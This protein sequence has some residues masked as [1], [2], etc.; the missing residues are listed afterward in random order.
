L[1]ADGIPVLFRPFHEHNHSFWWGLDRWGSNPAHKVL[2]EDFI[3]L[4]KYTVDYMKNDKGVRNFLYVYSP[5]GFFTTATSGSDSYGWGYPGDD[6][7]D[8]CGFDMYYNT[9][10]T[11][12]LSSMNLS[13]QVVN[14]FAKDHG[15][16]AALTE[17]G[18]NAFSKDGHGTPLADTQPSFFPTLLEFLTSNKRNYAYMQTWRMGSSSSMR[19]YPYLITPTRAFALDGNSSVSP[20]INGFLN[21]GRI[22]MAGSHGF[23]ELYK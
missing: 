7:V 5:N 8:I 18:Q 21:S 23:Y 3:R 20:F 14:D 12:N 19:Y 15:K 1:E 6:Y 13:C 9:G 16:V 22:V 17:F 10:S 2:P 11:N 4:W